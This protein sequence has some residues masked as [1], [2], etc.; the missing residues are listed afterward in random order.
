M[1]SAPPSERLGGD[2]ILPPPHSSSVGAV[3]VWVMFRL[4]LGPRKGELRPA[5]IV[6]MNESDS[7]EARL[8]VFTDGG[9]DGFSYG[10]CP[11]LVT[12]KYGTELGCW[13]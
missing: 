11:T 6:R 5:V 10:A 7:S 12:A 2:T 8:A 1:P 4:A 9:P 13:H 3:G